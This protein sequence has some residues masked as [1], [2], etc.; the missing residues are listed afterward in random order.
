MW[1]KNFF[2]IFVTSCCHRIQRLPFLPRCYNHVICWISPGGNT[3]DKKGLVWNFMLLT[4]F[5]ILTYFLGVLFATRTSFWSQWRISS[6]TF[7]EETS[8]IYSS[9]SLSSSPSE[10]SKVKDGLP[11][12]FKPPW[13]TKLRTWAILDTCCCLVN[14]NPLSFNIF[15]KLATIVL[16]L[17]CYLLWL[18]KPIRK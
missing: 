15:C 13:S 11:N 16:L 10:H 1:L 12:S 6:N 9:H 7:W 2:T 18:Q 14:I 5:L 3:Y 8:N 17:L 4:Q